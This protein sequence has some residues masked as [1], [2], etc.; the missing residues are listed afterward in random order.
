MHLKRESV[1]LH[2]SDG[3]DRTPQV[4]S[5]AQILLDKYYRTVQGFCVLIEKEWIC[6]GH[7]FAERLGLLLSD[8]T[9][10]V[11]YKDNNERAPIFLQFLDAVWQI[12]QQFPHAFEFSEDL[13]ITIMDHAYSARF[14]NFLFNASK[15][16]EEAKLSELSPSLWTFI[17]NNIQDYMNPFYVEDR[18]PSVLYPQPDVKNLRLWNRYY[19]RYFTDN[20]SQYE[21]KYLLLGK[22]MRG[23]LNATEEKLKLEKAARKAADEELQQ[24]RLFVQTLKTENQQ[25][26]AAASESPH[27][28]QNAANVGNGD[29]TEKSTSVQAEKKKNLED[30][31]WEQL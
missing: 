2:C 21:D 6:F 27:S 5:L 17:R 31:D 20:L 28:E 15:E 22:E 10:S 4:C 12:L 16:R 25:P 13:L 19:M 1:F 29:G 26:T 14:G 23:I 7:K 18:E 24:L 9:L 30:S 8:D 3:W 11:T